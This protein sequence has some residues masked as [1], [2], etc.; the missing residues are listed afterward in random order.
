M[1]MPSINKREFLLY[2]ASV[3]LFSGPLQIIYQYGGSK[4]CEMH[5]SQKMNNFLKYV[6]STLNAAL[7]SVFLA[8]NLEAWE[9]VPIMCG[10][11]V[12][13]MIGTRIY[14]MYFILKKEENENFN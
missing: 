5:L 4:L 6:S 7:L 9:F 1:F 14:E 10:I 13:L 12:S 8:F 2:F 3:S 11:G